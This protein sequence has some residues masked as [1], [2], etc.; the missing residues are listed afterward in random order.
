MVFAGNETVQGNLC[1][2]PP[3]NAT[4][5]PKERGKRG[6]G[7]HHGWRGTGGDVP[8]PTAADRVHRPNVDVNVAIRP[9]GLDGSM[10]AALNPVR[11]YSQAS[12]KYLF[13]NT[14]DMHWTGGHKNKRGHSKYK[15]PPLTLGDGPFVYPSGRAHSEG[16]C[17]AVT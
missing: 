6:G 2:H 16:N 15:L 3:L 4:S 13:Y 17:G 12:V 8:F 14:A 11:P 5:P 9:L 7:C 1:G 10:K